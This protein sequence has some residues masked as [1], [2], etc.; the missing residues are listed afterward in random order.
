LTA[1]LRGLALAALG[2][3]LYCTP[4]L[5][6]EQLADTPP[7]PTS[8]PSALPGARTAPP[9][10]PPGNDL[11]LTPEQLTAVGVVVGPAPAGQGS[12]R[13]IAFG[14]VIDPETLFADLGDA[15]EAAVADHANL[16]E[17]DRMR[18][19]AAD[20]DASPKM[21]EASQAERVKSQGRARAAAARVA[22]RWGPLARLS[23]GERERI[24]SDLGSTGGLLLR[25]DVVGRQSIA[26]L[27]R[28][29]LLDVDG[30]QV[31]ARVLGILSRRAQP[32]SAALLIAAA[33]APP[34][35]GAGARVPVTLL[36]APLTGRLLPP[37]A[38]FYDERGAFVFQRI[39][40]PGV[41]SRTSAKAAGAATS[42][43]SAFRTARIK[44][45]G[46]VDDQC[47]VAGIDD[48]D[49]VV[50]R[51]GGALW[52]LLEIH[53]HVAVGDDDD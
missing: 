38:I 45:L 10:A 35:L 13:T 49:Q 52:S 51:G 5:G 7:A 18:A 22:S 20:G 53:G 26:T 14:E 3:W 41:S 48:D 12:D 47:L 16:Q 31:S 34:G 19:L 21:L 27:P 8:P 2:F 25:A 4:S 39:P 36:T 17:L 33:N 9:S 11:V 43:A 30:V 50:L 42:A 28:A 24:L 37:D 44:L 1:T 46:R 29:A 32:Q 40:E 15:E 23:P 6:S